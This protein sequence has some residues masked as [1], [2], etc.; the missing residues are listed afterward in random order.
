MTTQ[1]SLFPEGTVFP[2]L[3]EKEIREKRFEKFR[4]EFGSH[5][6]I[7]GY[8]ESFIDP[9]MS[10]FSHVPVIDILKFDKWLKREH[11]EDYPDNGVSMSQVITRFYGKAADEWLAKQ[12]E[13]ISRS[14]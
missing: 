11:Y 3:T 7:E 5:F 14:Y 12:I 1:L 8:C 9:I 10:M 6:K 13:N 2:A 4:Q